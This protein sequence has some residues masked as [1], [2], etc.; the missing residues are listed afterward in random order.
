M[1]YMN[2]KGTDQPAHPRTLISA[3]VVRCLYRILTTLAAAIISRLWLASV[4]AQAV[5]SLTWPLT[6]KAGFSLDMAHMRKPHAVCSC[7]DDFPLLLLLQQLD[8]A[9]RSEIILTGRKTEIRSNQKKMHLNWSTT[10]TTK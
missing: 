2:N 8:P 3:F 4:A 5:F 10:K 6:F 9:Q 7:P 1:P